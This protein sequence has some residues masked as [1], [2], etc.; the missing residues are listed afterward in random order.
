LNIKVII[1]L[2]LFSLPCVVQAGGI[3]ANQIQRDVYGDIHAVG[4]VT[5]ESH[6]FQVQA[7]EVHMDADGV[8]GEMHGATVQFDGGYT[9]SGTSLQQL[10]MHR[11]SGNNISFTACPEDEWAWKISAD[12]AT[13][14]QEE[15]TFRAQNAWFEWGGIPLLYIPRWEHALTRRSGFLMP[16]FQQSSRR[17]SEVSVPYYWAASPNWD[18]T[19]T[20]HWMSLRGLMSDIEWRHRSL[21][22]EENLRLQNLYDEQTQTQRYRV[23]SDMGW[24]LAADID[25]SLN[26]DVVSDGLYVADFPL[27]GDIETLPYLTSTLSVAWRDDS[28]N[29]VLSSRYQQLLGGDSNAETLQILPRLQTRNYYDVGTERELQLEHQ[30]TMFQ[31]EVGVSGLR[32]GLRPSWTVP[33]QMYGSAIAATWEVLGQFTGYDSTDFSA[34]TSSYAALAS[35]IEVEAAFERVSDNQLWRHE[36]KP[37]LRL[38]MS[39]TPNQGDNP[40]YD[41]SLQPLS[42]SNL[43]HGNRYSGWD[44][45][46]RMQRLSMLLESSLQQKDENQQVRTILQGQLG[47]AWDY[48]QESVDTALEPTPTRTASNVLADIKW[49]PYASWNIALGGQHDPEL[50]QWVESHAGLYWEGEDEQFFNVSWRRTDESYAEAAESLNTNINL[51]INQR[52]SSSFSSQYDLLQ[53]HLSDTTIGLSYQHACWNMSTEIFKTYQVGTDSAT[54]SGARFL[55]VFEGLGSFGE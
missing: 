45:F 14:D 37:V 15:G 5:L 2:L 21:L 52:W 36:I 13:L 39:T 22:G 34:A 20:P 48:L 3:S 18:M 35:S 53:E 7:D 9:L 38:D 28:D 10:D 30:T 33:W 19:F 42:I 6:S 29:A 40:L 49:F 50:S 25:V 27:A 11:F 17:G 46:E 4:E 47:L 41:S 44:R 54:D 32:S 23:Q 12:E 16:E 1:S 43:M 24:V 26:V 31:R 8:A 51:S 55:L